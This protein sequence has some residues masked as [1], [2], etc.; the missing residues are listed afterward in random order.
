MKTFFFES[1]YNTQE[2]ALENL[3]DVPVF[4]V[5][6]SQEKGRGTTNKKW[7]NADQALAC[8][9]SIF[10]DEINLST[11][12][13]PLMS[14]YIFTKIVKDRNISLKWPNDLKLN[15]LKIGGILVEKIENKIVIG[16]GINYFWENPNIPG[17]GSLYDEKIQ[18]S[19]INED[20]TKWAEIVLTHLRSGDFN[21]QNYIEN[22]QTLGKLV[23]Y[24]EGRGWAR[25]V[26]D[27]GSL[28]IE[29]TDGNF[30]NLTSNVISEIE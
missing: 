29:T 27:D 28:Q 1:I 18:Y 5:S 13:I 23:E 26:N 12:L 2:F 14:G 17:A 30:I 21:I 9:L 19:Q 6:Y 8:S 4:V 25:K 16:M 3:K 15:N 11:G 24:P 7:S 10:E 20:A 22:L